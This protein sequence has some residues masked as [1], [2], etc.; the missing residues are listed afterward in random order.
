MEIILLKNLFWFS[1]SDRSRS[2]VPGQPGG[3]VLLP[4][5]SRPTG[6]TAKLHET[7]DTVP[8]QGAD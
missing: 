1:F 7:A 3:D 4:T 6:D 8:S 2:A 5:Q